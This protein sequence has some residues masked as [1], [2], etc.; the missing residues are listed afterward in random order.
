MRRLFRAPSFATAERLV[1]LGSVL[2]AIVIA[3]GCGVRADAPPSGGPPPAAPVSVAPAVQRAV[4]DTEEFSGRLEAA[5]YVE[6][7][8]RVAGVIEKIHFDDG[9]LVAKGQLLFSID[10]RP[11]DA[12]VARAQS[13]RSAALARAELAASELA[14][15][16]KLLEQRAVSRQEFDQLTAG[17]R[18]SD[19]D[20]QTAEAALRVAQLNLGYT[21]VHAPIA[22]RVSRA[23]VTAGNLVN[24]QVVLTSIA[25]T[26]KVYAYFEG[27]E[28]TYLRLQDARE[29]RPLVRM[30]LADEAGF[31][32]EGRI[33]FVDNRLNAL[34][35]AIRLRAS[36]S[37]A[38]GEFTP[39]MAVK[40][41]MPI[42][43]PYPA[44]LV[45][46]RAIGTDQSKKFV[47]VVGADAQPQFR[48]VK[49]GTLVEGMRV[50]QGNV[51]PG[52]HVVVDGLQRI[53][54]GMP[55]APQLLA[56]DARGMPIQA[57]A[58]RGAPA[59]AGPAPDDKAGQ[60]VASAKKPA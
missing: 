40:L 54:P 56:V 55:V 29:R 3:T 43:S 10:P 22:G 31:P 44:V 49:L 4:T 9:A 24:E 8:P 38:K 33:D 20:I 41:T 6:L 12:E 1:V 26:A 35:G 52:E 53:I 42:S 47:F 5:E 45:P 13:Q 50:V 28:Q 60:K 14:R 16:H 36:F 34:T 37:N 7:R 30:G 2:A 15:A 19:A 51:K 27:S 57:Q 17:S 21:Q 32:H 46:E 11:F 48:E 23:H 58:Q 39:G 25:G 18:T 59:A